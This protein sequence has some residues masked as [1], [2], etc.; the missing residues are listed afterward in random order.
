MQRDG[1]Y[2]HPGYDDGRDPGRQR[3]KSSITTANG[4]HVHDIVVERDGVY[5]RDALYA[6]CVRRLGTPYP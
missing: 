5:H 2:L 4:N 1:D 6:V 3:C